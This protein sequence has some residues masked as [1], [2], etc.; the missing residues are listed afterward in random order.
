M[1]SVGKFDVVSAS[2]LLRS[3]RR[4]ELGWEVGRCCFVNEASQ[5]DLNL[6]DGEEET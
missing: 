3:A 6:R 1:I 5:C 2:V 4:R